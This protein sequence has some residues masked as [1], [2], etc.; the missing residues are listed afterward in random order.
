MTVRFTQEKKTSL[1]SSCEQ[2]LQSTEVTT[3]K[4]SQVIGKIVMHGVLYYRNL[5]WDETVSLMYNKG[6]FE[7]KLH[8]S[9]KAKSELHWWINHIE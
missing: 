9:E 8:L 7:E 2:L 1:C 6:N 3:G 4:L 5:E